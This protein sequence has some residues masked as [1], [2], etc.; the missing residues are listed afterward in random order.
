MDI[1]MSVCD[2]C[3]AEMS[4]EDGYVLTSN[5][6]PTS[7]DY[8]IHVFMGVWSYVYGMDPNGDTIGALVQQQA[9]QSTGWLVCEGCSHM[10]SFNRTQAK[11]FALAH[12]GNPPGAGPASIESVASAAAEAWRHLYGSWPSSIKFAGLI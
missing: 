12:N 8:W 3:N 5:Q 11:S 2:V 4:W 7:K 1:P 9:G 10:F 6:V